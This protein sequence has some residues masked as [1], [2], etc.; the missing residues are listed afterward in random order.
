MR[1]NTI[2]NP[3]GKVVK[4]SVEP[5][6][7]VNL[8]ATAAIL[9]SLQ[10]QTSKR[11]AAPPA[12]KSNKNIQELANKSSHRRESKLAGISH[13]MVLFYRPLSAGGFV[14][15]SSGFL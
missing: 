1:E 4:R 10:L 12:R 7:G 9:Y 6:S 11:R 14:C 13:G 2:K 5:E 8:A 15:G 3:S